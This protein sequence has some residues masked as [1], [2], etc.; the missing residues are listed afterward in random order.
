MSKRAGKWTT[1]V[2]LA[3]AAGWWLWNATR[4][5]PLK[6][7]VARVERGVVERT[8]SNTRAG[9]V[10]ACQRAR[11][12]PATGGQI[13]RLPVH[14]GD[15]V[16][17]GQLLL[18]LWNDD[19]AARL[20]LAERQIEAERTRADEACALADVAARKAD[21]L[22]RLRKQKIASE[23]AV[24]EAVGEAEARRAACAAARA[25]VLV[26]EAQV[27]VARATLE[28]T[29]LRAPFAGIIAEVNGEIGEYVTP[30]PVGVATLPTVDLIDLS[31]VYVKA[32]ID[33]VDAGGITPG[34]E[35]RISVDAFPSRSFPA[36]VRRVAPYV[37]DVEKQARTVDVEVE[38]A[39]PNDTAAMLPGYSADV[40]IV[41][42]RRES[43]LRVPT[44]AVLEGDRVY[45]LGSDGTIAEQ[46]FEAGIAN[47][48]Y[49]EVLSGIEPDS[50]VVVSVDLE[51]LE[52]GARAVADR[53]PGG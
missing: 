37:L 16:R 28:R 23:E 38:F 42:E 43:T 26:S 39:D 31:C 49:T 9:T 11:M 19:L 46:P 18:E 21:R 4:G 27:D 6:V 29:R 2:V 45:V 22:V 53:S 13:A 41:L 40:E 1:V 17:A 51:G 33:E 50:V 25:S 7:R 36:R 48:Q 5:E 8:V 3:G 15:R 44:E 10:E 47:W 12:S 34:I 20:T 32:P 35:A 30:S 14:E 24:D 52:P